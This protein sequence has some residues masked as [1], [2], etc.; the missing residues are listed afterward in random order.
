MQFACRMCWVKF[1]TI[2][3]YFLTLQFC[4]A[5]ECVDSSSTS[6][7]IRCIQGA[8]RKQRNEFEVRVTYLWSFNTLICTALP[9]HDLTMLYLMLSCCLPRLRGCI[10]YH[11]LKTFNNQSYSSREPGNLFERNKLLFEEICRDLDAGL[12]S[13]EVVDLPS[14][15]CRK[16]LPWWIQ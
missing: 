9:V 7:L 5:S 13:N 10:L 11:W 14:Q 12:K 3:S 15:S 16:L 1:Q 2:K 6:W 8:S 4:C